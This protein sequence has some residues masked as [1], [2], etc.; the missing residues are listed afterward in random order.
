[1]DSESLPSILPPSSTSCNISSNTI[2]VPLIDFKSSRR[3]SWKN[4]FSKHRK[5]VY[6]RV[7]LFNSVSSIKNHEAIR[8]RSVRFSEPITNTIIYDKD[9]TILPADNSF[10]PLSHISEATNE[11]ASSISEEECV[12]VVYL[13]TAP[14]TPIAEE[15][16]QIECMSSSSSSSFD[17]IVAEIVFQNVQIVFAV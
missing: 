14:P 8:E 9:A 6:P 5:I 11:N 15:N 10:V 12:S 1:M 17:K 3:G 2:N 13:Q 7:S 16:A 4:M